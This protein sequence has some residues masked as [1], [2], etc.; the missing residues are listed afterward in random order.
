MERCAGRS[1][2]DGRT[3]ARRRVRRKPCRALWLLVV[4][5]HGAAGTGCSFVY[6]RGP[7]PEVQPPPPCTTSNASPTADTV[8]AVASVAAVVAGSIVYANGMKPCSGFLCQ[9]NSQSVGGGSAIVL[10]GIGTAV[11]VPS[12]I[13]GYNR[14]A[15]CRASQPPQPEEAAPS[16]PP[17]SSLLLVPSPGC[18]PPGTLR[19]FARRQTLGDRACSCSIRLHELADEDLT[20]GAADDLHSSPSGRRCSSRC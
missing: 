14:T 9:L 19:A 20:D 3:C 6:T 8:L 15:A 10:G 11:F 5:I 13:V 17:E 2:P 7:Q 16:A 18:P 4:T 1:G 12:A